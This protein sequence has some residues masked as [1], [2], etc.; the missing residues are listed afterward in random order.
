MIEEAR[1]ELLPVTP[2]FLRLVHWSGAWR[3][4][5]LSSVRLITYGAEPMPQTTLDSVHAMFPAAK[6]KQTYGLSELGVLRSRSPQDGS[7]WLQLGGDGVETRIRD[8]VLWVRSASSM[9]GYLNAPNPFDE[10]G[11][12]NTGDAVDERDGLIRFR[13][14]ASDIINVGGSKV[15]PGEVEDVLLTAA[16]VVD[17]TVVGVAH[18][19]LG[20]VPCA[21][22]TLAQPE[23]PVALAQRLRRHCLERL[24]KYKVPM[25]FY[26]SGDQSPMN[27][28]LKKNRTPGAEA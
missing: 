6:L 1:V 9:V 8:G 19:M 13:G 20:Q 28:R 15:F 23:S 24:A 21:T 11:W 17:A 3:H 5:D 22:V 16:N 2:S 12:M 14:R 18:P 4:S 10:E 7:L 26:T 27:A 25:R